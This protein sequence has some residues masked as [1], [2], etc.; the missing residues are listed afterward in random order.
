MTCRALFLC[1]AAALA[2]LASL[3]TTQVT[4][5]ATNAPARQTTAA[6]A[7]LLK[8]S[9]STSPSSS[10]VT[11]TLYATKKESTG[12]KEKSK[13]ATKKAAAAPKKKTEKLADDG[14]G[15][16]E[17][18]KINEEVVK[19]KKGDFV[20][21]LA[22]KTGMTKTQSD[23]ALTTVLN[24]I[25]TVS[26]ILNAVIVAFFSFRHNLKL[27]LTPCPSCIVSRDEYAMMMMMSRTDD[28]RWP[29]ENVSPFP[30]LERSN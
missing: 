23:L 4:A 3:H 9:I 20:T 29:T 10:S 13:S 25:A 17:N 11:T 2:A 12:K 19:F 22:E 6:G 16:G 15:D 24:V 26:L 14:D 1:V 18:D 30:A 21:A 27:I 7:L 8:G 28:R 5:F